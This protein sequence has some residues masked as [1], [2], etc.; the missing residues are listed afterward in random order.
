MKRMAFALL[1]VVGAA[2]LAGFCNVLI[3]RGNERQ[4][5]P[6]V[7]KERSADPE[8]VGDEPARGRRRDGTGR[9]GERLPEARPRRR[10][11]GLLR[12]PRPDPEEA[13]RGD[14][15]AVQAVLAAAGEDRLD[16]FVTGFLD[17]MLAADRP[18][19][20]HRAA[21]DA[22][23]AFRHLADGLPLPAKKEQLRA[24]LEAYQRQAVG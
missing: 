20:A 5:R 21:P 24:L 14:R 10:G 19:E 9:A 18:V 2:T 7:E 8:P 22:G 23:Q 11:R 6:L 15:A 16:E 17:A 13:V 1:A 12:R 4:A 3:Q